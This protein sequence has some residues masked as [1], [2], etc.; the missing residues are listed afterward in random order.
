MTSL[1][2]S[3]G[4]FS[5]ILFLIN[6]VFAKKLNSPLLSSFLSSDILLPPYFAAPPA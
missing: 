2:C 1:F 5:T 4:F 6:S 3:Y